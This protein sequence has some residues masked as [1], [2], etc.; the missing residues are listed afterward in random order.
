MIIINVAEFRSGCRKLSQHNH[1]KASE[2]YSQMVYMK[3]LG[4][5]C[6][7]KDL[8]MSFFMGR[9]SSLVLKGYGGWFGLKRRLFV[10][11]N[12][13]KVIGKG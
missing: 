13:S 1:L 10:L 7:L 11:L 8:G 4:K 5:T 6:N 12:G 3:Y 9:A 2:H